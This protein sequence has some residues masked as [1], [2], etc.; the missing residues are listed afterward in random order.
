MSNSQ[1]YFWPGFLGVLTVILVALK[2]LGIVDLPWSIA[3][4]PL[5]APFAMAGILILTL[6]LTEAA[7]G[8]IDEFG[9]GHGDR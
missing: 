4:M 1:S 5:W 8:L 2:L 9:G 7:R 6:F 3:L